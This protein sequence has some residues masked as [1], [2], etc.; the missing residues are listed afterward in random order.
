MQ[1][2]TIARPFIRQ[3]KTGVNDF[4]VRLAFVTRQGRPLLNH[5][6]DG[7]NYAAAPFLETQEMRHFGNRF[8]RGS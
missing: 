7:S 6:S 3:P 2:L 8:V 5:L 4:R 1:K